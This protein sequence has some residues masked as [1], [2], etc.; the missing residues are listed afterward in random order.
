MTV[1]AVVVLDDDEPFAFL[2]TILVVDEDK[3]SL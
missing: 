3:V 2:L 1:M